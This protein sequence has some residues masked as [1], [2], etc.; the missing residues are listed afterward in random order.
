MSET[1]CPDLTRLQC[2][3]V[4]DAEMEGFEAIGEHVNRCQECQDR[5]DRLIEDARLGGNPESAVV[6]VGAWSALVDQTGTDPH[7]YTSFWLRTVADAKPGH[8]EPPPVLP[9][10]VRFELLDGGGMGIVYQAHDT[11]LNRVVAVKVMRRATASDSASRA[12]FRREAEAMARLNHEGIVRVYDIGEYDDGAG[13]K[14]PYFAMEYVGGGTLA[15]RIGRR[16]LPPRDA[17]KLAAQLASGL[18][19][20]HLAGVIHRD[21]KPANILLTESDRSAPGGSTRDGR[22][23]PTGNL[24]YV[25][26]HGPTSET[27]LPIPKITDFGLARQIDTQA[28][29]TVPG[30]ILGTP[31]YMAPE[32]ARGE[33]D[34]V[35]P[36]SDV[37]SLGAVLYEM[38]TG[39]PP[40]EAP[41][42]EQTRR[43]VAGDQDPPPVRALQ[44]GVARDLETICMKCL[45]KDPARRYASA[46]AVGNDLDNWLAGRPIVA[47]PAGPIERLAKVVRRNPAQA[48]LVALLALTVFGG[49]AAVLWQLGR[50]QDRETQLRAYAEQIEREKESAVR[51]E[52]E[53]VANRDRSNTYFRM[54]SDAVHQFLLTE[55][56]QEQ[57]EIGL[58]PG[59]VR[60]RPQQDPTRRQ[61]L[62]KAEA[63]YERLL[64]LE[65][66]PTT[67]AGVD[68]AA[69]NQAQRTLATVLDNLAI[70]LEAAGDTAEAAV[71][72][73]RAL[74][75]REQLLAARPGVPEFR[76]GLALS[77]LNLGIWYRKQGTP[78]SVRAEELL[79]NAIAAADSL[80]A[81]H[82]Q[83]MDYLHL[84]SRGH[85][86]LGVLYDT[87][88]R[89]AQ[90]TREFQAAAACLEELVTCAPDVFRYRQDR[91]AVL[92]ELAAH[93]PKPDAEAALWQA[94]TAWEELACDH[95]EEPDVLD[96]LTTRYYILGAW[97]RD[98]G[99][100]TA[101]KEA[102]RMS[103][104]LS[105]GLVRA[106]PGVFG[107]AANLATVSYNLGQ[108]AMEQR[109]FNE[110]VRLF[111]RAIAI[112]DGSPITTHSDP[113]WF[114]RYSLLYRAYA[115][116]E[117]GRLNESLASL[118]RL[119]RIAPVEERAEIRIA[120]AE[121]LA[122]MGQH[123]IAV[124]EVEGVMAAGVPGELLIDAARV[125]ALAVVAARQDGSLTH[126][127]R[128]AELYASRTVG[129][130]DRL[131][132]TNVNLQPTIVKL[133]QDEP[134]FAPLQSRADF[135]VLLARLPKS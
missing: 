39:R 5:L 106:H 17:A 20:A 131:I 53:A 41:T 19:H 64:A 72:R 108:L 7:P 21:L 75:L 68:S 105:E 48:A 40:F 16:P 86:N 70:Y 77:H 27:T 128:V 79:S 87:T 37:Y 119:S 44:P 98:A 91:A 24:G 62:Q 51:S 85:A 47:R 113:T 25:T 132:D 89:R 97:Y 6:E 124:S 94:L 81:E 46:A 49:F 50:V 80:H 100:M 118:D 127:G 74:R 117:L 71:R 93:T 54:A 42:A 73:D 26:S 123:V 60:P 109:D 58:L 96:E 130:L 135:Q 134:V 30:T 2:W 15:R 76:H 90:A 111:D 22:R 115:L 133:I 99:R 126:A 125:M 69:W 56:G 45:E 84:K 78:G 59:R 107:Y 9:R 28:G 55:L 1:H 38:L 13:G 122:R 35:G 43:L 63:I 3:L 36:S 33:I 52:R 14:V 23:G 66:D 31:S 104:L 11:E 101:Q 116:G 95:P 67:G 120:R 121:N 29:A 82:P 57:F 114:F 4:G 32:Q 102:W 18:D 61:L 83:V 34:V 129:I 103:A 8:D 112:L 110:A 65:S 10:Y 88:G 92:G 12:R